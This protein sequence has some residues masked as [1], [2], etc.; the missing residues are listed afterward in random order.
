MT[1]AYDSVLERPADLS[2]PGYIFLGWYTDEAGT[3][4]YDFNSLVKGGFTL[5]AKWIK[6]YTVSFSGNGYGN[7]P[8]EAKVAEGGKVEKPE[9]PTAEG[10]VFG[11]CIWTPNVRRSTI[12][13]RR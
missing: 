9:D 2:A 8:A 7:I 5:Y 12:S 13:I 11:G 10:F 3:Q 1:A 4:E 6:A